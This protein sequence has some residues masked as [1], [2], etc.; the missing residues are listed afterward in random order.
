MTEIS[1]SAR[2]RNQIDRINAQQALLENLAT[3]LA[4]GKKTQRMSGL[5]NSLLTTTRARADFNSLEAYISNITNA[6]RRMQL[7]LQ[8]VNEIQAQAEN[9]SG[10]LTLFSK[11][12]V[13]QKGEEVL[14]DDP[15][16]PYDDAL[17]VGMT[18]SEPDVD[19]QSLID[20]ADNLYDTIASL[21]NARDTDTYVLGAADTTTQPL[22]DT[23]LLDSAIGSLITGWKNGTISNDE[24]IA[25]L[26]NGDTSSNPDAISDDIIGFS[27]S[28]SSGN[29][30]DLTVRASDSLE[31]DYS[32]RAN[33]DPFRDLLVGLAFLKNAALPPVA[34]TYTPPNTYPGAPD[35]EGA[36][37]ATLD[38]MKDN[39]FTVLESVA[40]MIEDAI[41]G[42]DTINFRV[43]TARA[44]IDQVKQDHV[45]A[46]NILADTIS[47]VEDVNLDEVAVQ[48]SSL[49]VQLEATYAVTAQV[50]QLS[51]VNF[52]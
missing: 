35:V 23:G 42:I 16:T 49:Q 11:E 44:R 50:Q 14:Y 3:Q 40:G 1:T 37:G 51:L 20:Y 46:Q 10:S 39:F 22:T 52:I 2:A 13:H 29:V 4:T 12:S 15:L 41:D 31:I 48:I 7:M 5:G 25:D 27:A 45:Q 19:F 26:T 17:R 33:E 24:L 36:P 30:G 18:S 47:D 43:E 34:D 6:D 9:F 28:L 32:V 8:S 21:V 38:E